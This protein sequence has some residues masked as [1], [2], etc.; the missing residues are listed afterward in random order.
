MEEV[1]RGKAVTEV[2]PNLKLEGELSEYLSGA[3]VTRVAHDR[4]QDRLHVYLTSRNWIQK[5]Y[6]YGLE[7]EIRRQLFS[8]IPI[9]VRVTEDFRLSRL[10]TPERLW[11]VYRPSMLL[12]C[13]RQDMFLYY[14]LQ[15]ADLSFSGTDC[16]DLEL[17]DSSVGRSKEKELKEYLAHVFS[18]RCHMPLKISVSWKKQEKDILEE[19]KEGQFREEAR[20]IFA[21]SA[22]SGPDEGSAA[23][24]GTAGG[25]SSDNTGNKTGTGKPD[26]AAEEAPEDPEQLYGR[27]FEGDS[28]DISGL[29]ETSGDVII[30]GR[31]ISMDT[32]E[33][34]NEKSLLIFAV[35]DETDTIRVKLFS[36]RQQAKTLESRLK[37]GTFVRV[38]GRVSMDAFEHELTISHVRGIRAGKDFRQ[39]RVD[40]A[41]VTRVELHCHTKM[42][43]MDGVSDAKDLIRRAREWGHP[44]I[45][46]TDHGVVQAFP[47]AKKAMKGDDSG[48]KVLY[49]CEAYIVDDLRGIAVNDK[50]QSL[51]DSYVVFDIETTGLSSLTC[52]IIEI[53]AVRVTDGEISGRFSTFVNPGIPIPFHIEKLTGISDAMVEDA[54]PIT[55]ALPA[56]LEFCGEDALV[57][58][59][60]D[61]DTG[62]IR[63]ACEEQGIP[64]A[65]T[66]VDTLEM[67]H[68]LIPQLGRF[69]LDK[70][71][72]AVQVPL[73]NHHRAVDDAACTA[74]IF[75]RFIGMLEERGI[76]T[77]KQMNEEG[78]MTP[79]AVSR[80]REHHAVLLAQNETGRVNL[81]RLISEAHLNYLHN[82]PKFPKSLINRYREGILVGSGCAD[83]E[84][85]Q[86]LLSG[87]SEEEIARLV[88]FYDYLEVQPVGNAAWLLEDEREEAVQSREDLEELVRKIVKLGE[89]FRKPVAATGDV[90]YLDPEDVLYRKIIKAGKLRK[91]RDEYDL[92]SYYL[93]TTNE[94]LEEF[95]FLGEEKAREIVVDNT[96]AIADRIEKISPIREGKFPPVIP[97]SDRTLREICENRAH[98]LY[99]QELPEIVAARLEKE[100]NSI[101]SNGYA[102]LY[103]IA[104]KLIWQCNEDGY[105]VGSRGSVGSSLAATMAGITEVNP[106][107][108]HYLCPDCHYA[109]FDSEIVRQFAAE[110]KVGCD[111][112]DRT[113]P[114]CGKPLQKL[115]F[116]IPF[117]T[118]LGFKGNKEPDIDLNF[119]GEY[120]SRAHK[121][122]EILFGKGQTFR[123]GTI[124]TMAE[125]TAF[126]YVKKYFEENNIYKRN[127]ELDRIVQG[128]VGVRRTTVQHPGGIIVVP[129]GED[130]NSFTPVQ[131]PADDPNSDIISTHFDYH[132][133]DENLLKL[134]LLGHDD[135]TMIKV[136]EEL[137]GT[138]A[139][140]VPLDEPKVMS[141]FKN[142]EALGIR[143]ED[144]GGCT[145]GCL[146][147]PEFGTDNTMQMVIEIRPKNLTDLIQISGLAHGTDVW[148]GNAQTLI[149]DGRCSISEAICTRDDIMGYLIGKGLDSEESFTIME[150]VRKGAVAKGSC[151]EWP[152]F[153]EDMQQHGVPDWYIWSCEKIKYMFPK[154]HA[155]AYVMMA[156]RIAW[157]KIYYPLAYYAAYFSIRASAFSY[158]L[159]CG[160]KQK[161]KS[162][163]DPLRERYTNEKTRREMTN[164]EKDLYRD[165]RLAEEMYAR[166]FGFV[167]ID[168]YT[169]H[170][171]RFRI[172][173]NNLMASL[174]A[175]E[176]LGEKAAE[177]IVQSA[178]EGPFLS[179][180]DFRRRTRTA[181]TMIE[182]L[183]AL[184]IL[185]DLP[186]TDQISLMDLL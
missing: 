37:T 54:P 86:A 151:K 156:Y 162:F 131:H 59:N 30:R 143:P 124:G 183:D 9:D 25:S 81:Y 76:G 139:T 77:L 1:I 135:P 41:A 55:E 122:T 8:D 116:Q 126:G 50:G 100:L 92:D 88:S 123:A 169:V 2:F 3:E 105:L 150:R 13:R 82:K 39:K 42:S 120:Q 113:C 45:A 46:I 18:G 27:F 165:M 36:S 184:G 138:D 145:L 56:F 32:R 99:G 35:T 106:L 6:I 31:I 136:L 19:E 10:Y 110:R 38:Q 112:P 67:A 117:E 43:E 98:E 155:V 167:P 29:D 93:R 137:T 178:A 57:A 119:S 4:R 175:I 132:S 147:V 68:L 53:G 182:K 103:I 180:D 176:G 154:A 149:R 80:L 89:Q 177:S 166:G 64:F 163:L 73:D 69:T 15:K 111:L 70:V 101:I 28:T 78:A 157:Y 107:P 130:I 133:I 181:K 121:N 87:A 24:N 85:Y 97:D 118:F 94:M 159:M 52:R 148:H 74:G 186:D 75:T 161:L 142:T 12:E 21:R 90:H 22:G 146:G 83:G 171:H 72:K 127:C 34:K 79:H 141:L 49:G 108:P 20:Q 16:L 47:E 174:D 62:F 125:K 173:G 115:G 51:R 172:V 7:D 152:Q 114:R 65:Y 144:I 44:A 61:F 179:K 63:R 48:F 160:G 71:A 104:Q 134:D 23:E 60:A 96:R 129:H 58:H 158:E 91:D 164:L 84:L 11:E 17:E 128:C 153:R 185:K 66:Y 33:L 95:S 168:L 102:V 170:A 5:K 26:Q 40:T 14:L 109:D 140:K